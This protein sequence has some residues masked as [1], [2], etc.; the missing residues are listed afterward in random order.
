V[1]GQRDERLRST[2]LGGSRIAQHLENTSELLD[3]RLMLADVNDI[4]HGD[5][6]CCRPP[7]GPDEI[8]IDTSVDH[9]REH[10]TA[11]FLD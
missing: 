7:Q 9:V 11:G 2:G 5:R 8:S 10:A 3:G 6:G 1:F 4:Q